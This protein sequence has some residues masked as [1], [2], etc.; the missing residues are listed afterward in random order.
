MPCIEGDFMNRMEK[1]QEVEDLKVLFGDAQLTVLTEY[2]G[3]DVAAMTSLR[4]SLRQVETG[5]RVVKNTLARLA[6]VDTDNEVLHPHLTGPLGV[7]FA[8][9][10]PAAA[11]KA[12]TEFAKDH[13]EFSIRAGVLSGGKLLEVKEIEALAKLPGKDQLRAMLLGALSGVPR[14][15]V[16]VLTAP[17]RDFVGVLAA[18]QRQLEEAS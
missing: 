12:L 10:D 7:A 5:Y 11:A 1:T 16:T 13:D 18:R 14:Q 15:F 17:S 3:L 4:R 6:T 9:E 8:N 2:S